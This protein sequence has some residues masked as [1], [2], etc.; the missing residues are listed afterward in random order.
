MKR[1]GPSSLKLDRFMISDLEQ[2]AN[3][4]FGNLNRQQ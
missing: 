1:A 2:I 4:I 3:L